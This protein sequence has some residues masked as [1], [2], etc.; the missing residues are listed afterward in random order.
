MKKSLTTLTLVGFISLG[1][2]TPAVQ[3]EINYIDESTSESQDQSNGEGDEQAQVDQAE[4]LAQ[5]QVIVRISEEGYV[6][7]HG[8]HYHTYDG[9][10]PYEGIYADSL[11][12]PEDYQFDQA[13]VYTEVEGGYIVTID[14]KCYLY[15][16]DPS[17]AK[18]LRT[19]D[20]ITLQSYG[21]H[22]QDATAIYQ[23]KADLGLKED[24]KISFENKLMPADYL[25][26][27][28]LGKDYT[29]VYLYRDGFATLM[30]DQVVVFPKEAPKDAKFDKR[31]LLEDDQAES[32]YEVDGGSVVKDGDDHYGLSLEAGQDADNLV[33]LNKN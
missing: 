28:N 2:S 8:D 11:L 13:D 30:G 14:D 6:T 19:K 18:N 26:E 20:E 33:D 15:Y 12:A 21:L 9:K 32:V 31:L 10:P 5:E 22:P 4:G 27:S 17:Q 29:V 23:L 1:L 24:A 16:E 25:K 3:A 7:S